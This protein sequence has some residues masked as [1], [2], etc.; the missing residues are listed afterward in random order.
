MEKLS[1]FVSRCLN[2]NGQAQIVG[3]A[4]WGFVLA[5]MLW[6]FA[7]EQ[8]YQEIL[9]V[10][11]VMSFLVLIIGIWCS[12]KALQYVLMADMLLSMVVLLMYSMYDPT[13]ATQMVYRVDDKGNFWKAEQEVSCVFTNTAL[14]WSVL[15]SAYLANL[16]QRQ[17]L[18]QERFSGL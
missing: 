2:D 11:G 1:L 12:K 7:P 16:I 4:V 18:E 3:Y 15:H 5:G 9:F 8:L 14:V 13:F 10:W 6:D 17:I